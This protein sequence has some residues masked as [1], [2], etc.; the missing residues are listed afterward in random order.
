MRFTSSAPKAD[1]EIQG[2]HVTCTHATD[3]WSRIPS[4][5]YSHQQC[6]IFCHFTADAPVRLEAAGTLA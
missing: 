4:L 5:L 2:A 1:I 3:N 6:V